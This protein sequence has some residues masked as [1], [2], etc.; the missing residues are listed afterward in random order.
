MTQI[1]NM[2]DVGEGLTEAEVVTWHV[3]VGDE[4]SVNQ[5]LIE[6]ET[7][8]A[9]VDLPS[10]YAGVVTTL[11]C[12]A[13]DVVPVGSPIIT[14][15]GGTDGETPSDSPAES[16]SESPTE[17]LSE[18]RDATVATPEPMAVE[19]E[20]SAPRR[21]PVLVG[22]GTRHGEVARRRRSP[23][24]SPP[25]IG[26]GTDERTGRAAP[27]TPPVRK[28]ARSLGVDPAQVAPTGPR[29][30]VTRGDVQQAAAHLTPT[31]R[32]GSAEPTETRIPVKGVRKHIAEA[33]VTSAFTAPHVTEWIT[34]DITR[35]LRLL[36]DLRADRAFA[37]VRL[38][39]LVMVARAVVLSLGR[40][41]EINARW[42]D[43]A[44]EIVQLH[45]VGL[46]IA[47]ASPRGLIV[48]NVAAA[49][50]LSFRELAD[51]IAG[52]VED[53]RAN[54]TTPER[55]RGGTF[56]ITNVGVFGV[57]G[58]TPIL[59]PGESAILSLGST[60]ERPWVHKGRIRKRSVTTLCLSFDHRLV[61]GELGSQFLADVG[62][63]LES[64]ARALSW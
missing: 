59:N 41:P 49:Q 3:Q 8:K 42:D 27:I 25:R 5:T 62:R 64:P 55:M 2:P 47:V 63:V 36:A 32:T 20:V 9:V 51:A 13:G 1:F 45:D 26:S 54:R 31:A 35:T 38:T 6:V 15:G 57:E 4:V 37:N 28:L 40:H 7:A 50:R 29:G 16:P 21:E 18:T 53:G 17:A 52:L 48:P 60:V 24:W 19:T 61:D 14:I 11:H 56:T 12:A 30:Q 10:P 23:G 58:A 46:G 43:A 22:Y 39:P 33:M 34:V 44:Q